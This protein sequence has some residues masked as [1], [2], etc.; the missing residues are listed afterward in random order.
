MC[1]PTPARTPSPSPRQRLRRQRRTGRGGGPDRPPPGPC[2]RNPGARSPPR[3][4]A[5]SRRSAAS[6]ASAPRV[7]EDPDRPGREEGGLVALVVRGDHELNAIKAQKLRQV[8]PPLPSPAMR[9]SAP[10][11]AAG[12]ARSARS[13]LKI[14][15]IVDRGAA[16]VADFVCGANEDGKHLRGRQLG[17]RP[18]GAP[19]A[20]LRNVVEGDPSPD[21]KGAS[22]MAR[23]RGRPHL[24]ARHQVQRGHEGPVLDENG[25]L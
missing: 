15:V 12:R 17:P 24:P 11:S 10:P 6:S 23:H 20:D 22:T 3:T 16:L 2:E 18:A 21:G 13:G 1:W 7:P 8:A 4:S 14:P 19:A 25:R 9:R 5:P